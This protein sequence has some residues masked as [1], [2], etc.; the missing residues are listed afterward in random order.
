[1]KRKERLENLDVYGKIILK[2]ILKI[3]ECGSK[4]ELDGPL[5]THRGDEKYKILI[6]KLE[7]KRPLGRS[8]R[9]WED[10]IEV[11]LTEMGSDGLNWIQQAQ[12]RDQCHA[13]VNVAMNLR[14][15]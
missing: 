7:G 12:D 15:P 5:S 3:Y 8:K 6:G 13:L 14:V 9:I 2:R 1:V 11:D 10:N 4:D